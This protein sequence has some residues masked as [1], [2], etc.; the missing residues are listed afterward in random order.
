M[1]HP[2]RSQRLRSRFCSI[3]ARV[4][5]DTISCTLI[6]KTLI[7]LERTACNSEWVVHCCLLLLSACGARVGRMLPRPRRARPVRRCWL[8]LDS[9][10]TGW[11][12]QSR[13]A[14]APRAPGNIG[15]DRG[16][17][18]SRRQSSCLCAQGKC[19]TIVDSNETTRA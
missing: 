15:R 13:A 6:D 2:P 1:P 12:M 14:E 8:F 10:G 19:P 9:W 18:Q 16:R 3:C 4:D 11:R 5:G 17:P 7:K